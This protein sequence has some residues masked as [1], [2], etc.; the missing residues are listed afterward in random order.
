MSH[1]VTRILRGYLECYAG[2][3]P[4]IHSRDSPDARRETLL[5]CRA[6][7]DELVKQVLD[8]TLADDLMSC[9]RSVSEDTLG[10][11][12]LEARAITSILA[13]VCPSSNVLALSTLFMSC[14]AR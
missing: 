4:L 3:E 6:N 14:Q 1:P 11:S 8:D 13:A 2:V 10:R 5:M 12:A 7:R 9:L